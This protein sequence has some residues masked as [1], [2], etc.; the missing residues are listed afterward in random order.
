MVFNLE[1]LE[2]KLNNIEKMSNEAKF[3]KLN[4]NSLD[5]TFLYNK[6]SIAELY[7]LFI[8]FSLVPLEST[9]LNDYDVD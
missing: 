3:I 2:N 1:E 9:Q 8:I 5:K 7:I 4:D 6:D